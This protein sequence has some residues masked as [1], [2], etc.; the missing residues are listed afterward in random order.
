MKLL[1]FL[2]VAALA[3]TWPFLMLRRPWAQRL[4]RRLRIAL[5]V[6]VV[7]IVTAAAVALAFR[8]D[9]IYG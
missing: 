3:A 9:A 2:L 8:W 1:L 5:V 6:Y 4:W 7:A